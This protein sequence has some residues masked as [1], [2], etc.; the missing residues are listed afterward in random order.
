[1]KKRVAGE[2]AS[3][4][5]RMWREVRGQPGGLDKSYWMWSEW[6]GFS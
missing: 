2:K 4:W 5:E 1:M 6:D 3:R